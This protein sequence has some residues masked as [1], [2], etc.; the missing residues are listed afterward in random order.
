MR[1]REKEYL[2]VS[3]GR[4]KERERKKEYLWVDGRREKKILDDTTKEIEE[5]V[6]LLENATVSCVSF[7]RLFDSSIEKKK[8]KTKG[9][10]KNK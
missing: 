4:E 1:E 3:G 10:S 5:F 9:K 6:L 2:W 7:N 8:E